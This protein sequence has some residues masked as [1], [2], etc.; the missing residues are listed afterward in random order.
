MD[1]DFAATRVPSLLAI[2]NRTRERVCALVGQH[3]AE[4]GAG[5]PEPELVNATREALA[6]AFEELGYSGSFQR[7]GK[8]GGWSKV[9][10]WEEAQWLLREGAKGTPERAL[11]RLQSFV[12]EN[13]VPLQRVGALWGL[14]PASPVP[15]TDSLTL[16]AL[17]EL[18]PSDAQTAL[19]SS[20]V[21]GAHTFRLPKPRAALVHK[22]LHRPVYRRA[23]DPAPVFTWDDK[24]FIS[25]LALVLVL[26][27]DAPVLCVAEWY[28][29]LPSVPVLGAGFGWGASLGEPRITQEILPRVY[30]ADR[31]SR[32]VRAF[33]ALEPAERHR[34]LVALR[35]LNLAW[36]RERPSDIAL[37]V[38]IALEALLTEP[39]DPNDSI[40]Y[41][42]Q[43]R[44]AVLLGGSAPERDA[45]AAQVSRLYALRSAAVHGTDIDWHCR[46]PET[47]RVSSE[48]YTAA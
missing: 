40:S 9:L 17:A 2:S 19:M 37:E 38:G 32:H 13:S 7:S 48:K 4:S 16:V 3:L 47:V 36:L 43:I 21:G 6:I 33:L 5:A 10:F 46:G 44:A 27:A 14:H 15:L 31:A 18:E 34:L 28:Q 39:G 42:L 11:D 20:D 12:Q 24:Y 41:R 23:G 1:Q 22:F 45:I 26:L 29:T 35:R 8:P 25:D 30:D